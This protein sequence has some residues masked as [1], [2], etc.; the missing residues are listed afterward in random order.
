MIAGEEVTKVGLVSS[1]EVASDI[2]T[3]KRQANAVGAGEVEPCPPS[4]PRG[5]GWPHEQRSS[6]GSGLRGMPSPS[7]RQSGDSVSQEVSDRTSSL[8]AGSTDD[9][10]AGHGAQHVCRSGQESQQTE[11]YGA[12]RTSVG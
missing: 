3:C 7:S 10:W 6:Q 9:G 4:H 5:R 12:T 2:G 1:E 8:T 11:R